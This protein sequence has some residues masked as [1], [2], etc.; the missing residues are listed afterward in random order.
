MNQPKNTRL[1]ITPLLP[2]LLGRLNKHNTVLLQAAPGAGKTTTVPP[3]L[4]KAGWRDNKKILMLEPRRLAARAA[5]RFMAR[6]MNEPVGQTVGYRVRLDSKVS[7]QTIIE[8]VTEGIL[9]RLIQSDPELSDY[10]IVI[11]D[12]FHERSL[13]ADLGLALTR[14]SQQVLREDLRV[15]IMSATLDIEPLAQLLDDAPVIRSDGRAHPVHVDY[16]ERSQRAA[17]GH[18]SSH[19]RNLPATVSRSVQRALKE[20]NGSILVFLPGVG[21]IRKTLEQ[22]QDDLSESDTKNSVVL[23]PLFGDLS[24]ADQ[25]AAIAPAPA[26]MRKIV[27][28]TSI[29]ESSLTIEGIRIVIDTGLQRRPRFDP[30]S[31]MSRLVTER[32]SKAS[33]DQRAG[34]A[35]RLEPGVCFRLWSESEP[36]EPFSS[37]EI[38]A[39]DLAPLVLELARWGARSPD[40]MSWLNPPPAAH[41]AQARDLLQ[42]LDA[43]DSEGAITEHGQRM[44][45]LGLHPRLSHLI[46][47]GRESGWDKTVAEL[48]ALLSERDILLNRQSDGPGSDL[49]HRLDAL[50]GRRKHQVHRGR[51]AQVQ[52]LARSLTTGNHFESDDEAPLGALLAL[53]FPDRVAQARGRRGQFRLSNGRG[54]FLFEDDALAGSKFLIAAEL[55]GQARDARIF[56]ATEIS[57]EQLESALQAHIQTQIQADWN[58]KRGAVIAVEQRTLGALVL[59]EKEIQTLD[60]QTL[61]TGLLAAIRRRGLDALNWSDNARQWRARAQLAHTM[62]PESWPAFDNDALLAELEDWLAP[63]FTDPY[64]WSDLKRID[65]MSALKTRLDYSKQQELQTWFPKGIKLPTGH[66][67]QLDYTAEPGPVL[68]TKLQ[69]LFGWT[70]TPTVGQQRHPVVIHLLSPAG[71]PLAVTSDLKSF[72]ANAYPDVRKD[73][74]GR[75][76]KHPWPEDPLT[77]VAS[78]RTKRGGT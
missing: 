4:L 68:A 47:S 49:R 71:R 51:L 41:W 53:A 30:N 32:V 34:R 58:D 6:A 77:A 12:E 65:L 56:L 66:F 8:V 23:A 10:A 36:L 60:D 27:L 28:A 22:L 37:P 21:E 48:A 50:R 40:E 78:H 15:L 38:M 3:A 39:A 11:F 59:D 29:A 74:R 33:A 26:G 67:A 24:G 5:A 45:D 35:G 64:R 1:P 9:T 25:D 54:A 46:L 52:T 63:F 43:L 18:I 73:M 70:K 31:G 62:E 57:R 14:E 55:D 75:Y 76:P 20:Q 16:L 42:L 13:Q 69:A 44:L 17:A 61:Q 72:W 2:D 19:L 7:K